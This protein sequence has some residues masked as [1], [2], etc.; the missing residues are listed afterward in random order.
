MPAF[1]M[2]F[3]SRE[4]TPRSRRREG[5]WREGSALLFCDEAGSGRNV[6]V[7]PSHCHA[8]VTHDVT[9]ERDGRAGMPSR[10]PARGP[11]PQRR[12]GGAERAS[13]RAE[14][15]HET[16]FWH[17]LVRFSSL[18]ARCEDLSPGKHQVAS[19]LSGANAGNPCQNAVSWPKTGLSAARGAATGRRDKV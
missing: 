17:R 18:F 9:E 2:R 8:I 7:A 13:P 4:D 14:N 5:L 1:G 11:L 19:F 6:E 16:A 3:S 12:R 10:R 15:G